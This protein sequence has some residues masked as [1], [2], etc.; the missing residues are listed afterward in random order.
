LLKTADK[1]SSDN[2]NAN[3]AKLRVTIILNI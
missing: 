3:N 1:I 2:T